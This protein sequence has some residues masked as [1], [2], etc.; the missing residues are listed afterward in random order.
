MVF[1]SIDTKATFNNKYF[2]TSENMKTSTSE[3]T[4]SN[5]ENTTIDSENIQTE[6]SD[7][8][9]NSTTDSDETKETENTTSSEEESAILEES[10]YPMYLPSGTYLS[11][12]ESVS[13]EDGNRVILTFA[14]E[15]P[16]ILVEEAVSKSSEMEIIPVSGEPIIIL[17]SV[18]ALSDTS[19]NFI[20]N[21]IEYYIA[22]ENLT[23]QEI[24]EVA[25]SISTLPSMK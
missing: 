13:K 1:D 12:E 2:S 25:E 7:S 17:D 5:D 18:A 16:F 24:I 14:G 11:D 21:G 23:T 19:V 4:E 15:S 6:D 8:K 10:V 22:S 9:S 3:N 20:S